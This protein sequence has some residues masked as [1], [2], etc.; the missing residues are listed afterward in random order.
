MKSGRNDSGESSILLFHDQQAW[1]AWL[2]KNHRTSLG[3]WLRLAKKGSGMQSA[4]YGEALDVALCYG[5]IDG[6]KKG[7]SENACLQKFAPRA[8]RSIWSQINRQKALALIKAG[9]MKP[10]GMEAIE[11]AKENGRWDAAYESPGMATVPSDFQAVLDKNA[12]AKS[13]FGALDRGNRYAVLFRIQ[14]AKKPETRIK[15]IQ[16]FIKMLEKHERVHPLSKEQ[17]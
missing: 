12:R 4:S 16:R 15:R 2:D 3:V 7:E 14:T 8:P 13:F 6:Q 1:A 10:F 11:R 9:Q 17:K 5:W